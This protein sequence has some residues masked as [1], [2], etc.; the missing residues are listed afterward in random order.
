MKLL[1]LLLSAVCGLAGA[2]PAMAAFP[3]KPITL[4]VPF[5]PGGSTDVHLR[6]LANMAAKE[7]KQPVII[8][9]KPGASGSVALTSIRSA[10]PD[11]TA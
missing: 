7:L 10:A 1:A 9:N 5:P 6:S 8:E 4:V 11:A 2:A 3:E